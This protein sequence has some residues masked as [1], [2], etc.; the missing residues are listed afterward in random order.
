MILLS[1]A[2]CIDLTHGLLKKASVTLV[3][4]MYSDFMQCLREL[5]NNRES[6]NTGLRQSGESISQLK[7]FMKAMFDKKCDTEL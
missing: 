7:V 4:T 1:A 2:S 5:R 6:Y 3:Y